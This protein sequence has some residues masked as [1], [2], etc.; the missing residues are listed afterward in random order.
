MREMDLA[1]EITAFHTLLPKLRADHKEGWVVI[2]GTNCEGSFPTFEAAA[3]FAV[4]TFP[5]REFLIRHTDARVAQV[6]F[7]LVES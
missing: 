6:P 1:E 2:V 5:D 4:R 3:Q 7:I